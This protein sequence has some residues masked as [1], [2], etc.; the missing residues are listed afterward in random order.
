MNEW[1]WLCSNTVLFI[2]SEIWISCN[3]HIMKYYPSFDF[4][5][6]HLEMWKVFWFRGN[7]TATSTGV[8][9]IRR[10]LRKASTTGLNDWLCFTG[11]GGVVSRSFSVLHLE[12]L[13]ERWG[14]WPNRGYRR[15]KEFAHG[16]MQRLTSVFPSQWFRLRD[17]EVWNPPEESILNFVCFE[18]FVNLFALFFF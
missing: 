11:L 9:G 15:G 3:F 18:C 2:N 14:L 12:T 17:F 7:K 8:M 1:A 6:N 16:G 13:G 10:E 4:F 5:P